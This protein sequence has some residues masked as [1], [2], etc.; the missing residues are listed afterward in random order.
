[1]FSPDNFFLEGIEGGFGHGFGHPLVSWSSP[2]GHS[3]H[4]DNQMY[5]QRLPA[6]Q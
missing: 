5:K 2:T 4:K 3:G 1:L 6:A